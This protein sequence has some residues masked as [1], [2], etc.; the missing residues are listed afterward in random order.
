MGRILVGEGGRMVGEEAEGGVQQGLGVLR[1]VAAHRLLARQPGV[2]DRRPA[3]GGHDRGRLQEVVGEGGD[4]V[5]AEGDQAPAQ[6]GMH[7]GQPQPREVALQGVPNE[8]VGEADRT[9]RPAPGRGRSRRA[10]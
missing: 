3:V 10:R 1:G 7:A 8:R 9:W 5:R 4:V 6:A 2:P